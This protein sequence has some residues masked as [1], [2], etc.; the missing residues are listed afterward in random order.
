ME[1]LF[2]ELGRSLPP[3]RGIVHGAGSLTPMP[4]A[5]LDAA[6]LAA[7]LRPKA[8]GGGLLL[9]ELSAGMDLD[10]F[11]LL[12]SAAGVWGSRQLAHY[13]AANRF[14]DGLAW[15]RQSLGLP[16]TSVQSGLWEGDG[17]AGEL[18]TFFRSVGLRRMAADQAADAVLEL[19]AAGV[20]EAV[21][22]DVDW[23][24][25]APL[26]AA[27]GSGSL[28]DELLPEPVRDPD[29]AAPTTPADVRLLV[30]D[31]VARILGFEPRELPTDQGFFRLGMDS[32]MSVRL[33]ARLEHS[34]GRPLPATIALEY[35]TVE[36]LAGYLSPPQDAVPADALVPVD[37]PIPAGSLGDAVDR[38]LA[39]LSDLLSRP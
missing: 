30:R 21:L 35:P 22:A 3:L 25:F 23:S 39:A 6:S 27:R 5:G 16:A 14:L 1:A 36:A 10:L 12:S 31:E 28:L 34:L 8:H 15:Y 9:H 7:V 20:C 33:R 18:E 17:I 26:Y 38:E 29:G 4:L 37:E 2:A 19:A 32:V 13:A 11:V 24:V